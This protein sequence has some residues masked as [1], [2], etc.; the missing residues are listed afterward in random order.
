MPEQYRGNIMAKRYLSGTQ[1]CAGEHW[2][3]GE[4]N[5]SSGA[6]IPLGSAEGYHR[7][8]WRPKNFSLNSP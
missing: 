1:T 8:E 7:A 6:W 3:F 4:I 2:T 5:K